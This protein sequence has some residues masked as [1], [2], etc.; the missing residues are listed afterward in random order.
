[1]HVSAFRVVVHVHGHLWLIRES[2]FHFWG[3]CIYHIYFT[4]VCRS[5]LKEKHPCFQSE[6]RGGGGMGWQDIKNIK[7]LATTHY[8]YYLN[9]VCPGL[10]SVKV[11]ATAEGSPLLSVLDEPSGICQWCNSW[12]QA[13][14][15]PA[16]YPVFGWTSFGSCS[17]GR[18]KQCY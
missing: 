4:S 8:Y 7:I 11:A 14:F 2:P 17:I 10:G 1:M 12:G 6:V 3:K 15:F 13:A 9:R 16:V 5:R 18:A